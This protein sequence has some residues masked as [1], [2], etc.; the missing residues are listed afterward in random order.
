MSYRI[1]K[2]AKYLAIEFTGDTSLAEN[3]TARNELITLLSAQGMDSVLVDM[4]HADL[5]S[6]NVDDLIRFGE[7]WEGLGVSSDIRFATLIPYGHPFRNKIDLSVWTAIRTGIQFRV[8]EERE[9]AI[10]WLSVNREG[11]IHEGTTL[12]S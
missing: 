10:G 6:V 4:S 2:N 5:S 1:E 8:F 11:R 9:A 7:D 3:E 12:E